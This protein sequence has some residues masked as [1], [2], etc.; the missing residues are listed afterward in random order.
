MDVVSPLVT[1][2][3]PA[4]FGDPSQRPLHDPSVPS[5][6]LGA[7]HTLP[8]YAALDASFS[9]SSRT[10]FVV[11]GFVGVK[12]LGSLPRPPPRTLD[13]PDA[14]YEV[15]EDHRIVYVRG[16]AAH[17]ERDAR[18]LD[19]KVA[20]RARLS[21]IRRIPAGSRSPLLF[22]RG[23]SPSPKRRAPNLFARPP[24]DDPRGLDAASPILQPRA[25]PSGAANR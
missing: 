24:R 5:Q 3:E 8:G 14:V 23:C 11:V 7:L 10:L 18:S 21:L 2:S 9:Q 22:W 19:H 1:N 20:L 16:G 12:L 15:L 25:T 17:C 6:L 13:R 4:V